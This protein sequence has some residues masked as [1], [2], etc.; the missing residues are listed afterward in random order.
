[1]PVSGWLLMFYRYLSYLVPTFL[2]TET[3][4]PSFSVEKLLPL[5]SR[6]V[7]PFFYPTTTPNQRG[8]TS[9]RP[10]HLQYDTSTGLGTHTG[11][12]QGHGHLQE[13]HKEPLK[14]YLQKIS[15]RYVCLALLL[16]LLTKCDDTASLR[17][18]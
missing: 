18:K 15:I 12:N 4:N 5:V 8:G 17:K 11:P 13:F 10:D 14:N 9:P 1:M 6:E 2:A 3:R 16:N 7:N